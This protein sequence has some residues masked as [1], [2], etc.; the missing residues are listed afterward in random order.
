[1]KAEGDSHA[2]DCDDGGEPEASAG[3][4]DEIPQKGVHEGESKRFL[5]G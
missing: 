1:M 2:G 5:R 3:A 4:V